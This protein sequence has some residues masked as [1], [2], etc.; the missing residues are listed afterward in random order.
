MTEFS[1]IGKSGNAAGWRNLL[2]VWP[3]ER[4][5]FLSIG[6][7]LALQFSL[8]FTRA[9]N[10]DEFF[11]FSEVQRFAGGELGRGLQTIHVRLFEWLTFLPGTAVDQIVVGRVVMFGFELVTAASIA[12]VARRFASRQVA[13]SCALAYLSAGYVMQHGASFRTDPMATVLLMGAL[14]ILTRSRMNLWAIIAF[15]MLT[16]WSIMVTIKVVLY[17]PAFAGIAWL[18][19]REANGSP[20][21]AARIALAGLL[22]LAVFGITYLLHAAPVQMTGSS[23]PAN[24]VASSS[25]KM[26]SIG[27]PPYWLAA[28]KGAI[29]AIPLT[30]AI[31]LVPGRLF[32]SARPAAER[33]ALAGLFAPLLSLLFYHNTAPYYYAFMLPPVVA[34]CAV[35]LPSMIK[36]YQTA[37]VV[38][39]LTLN[40][41]MV[42]AL[43]GES[44]IGNQRAVLQMADELFPQGTAYFDLCYML[45][46][47]VKVNGFMTPWGVEIYRRAGTPTFANAMAEQPVPLIVENDR[48]FTKLLRETGSAPAF[49][50]ED[51]QA[52]RGSYLPFWGPLWL[53]GQQ[54]SA[55][56]VRRTDIRVPGPY[57]VH[58]GQVTI[59][60]VTYSK[61]ATVT[62]DRGETVLAAGSMPV[63]L[64]WGEKR[65]LPTTA[66][67]QG[68]LWTGF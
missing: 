40:G 59:S 19:W 16:G 6:L 9:I 2:P 27:I 35:S 57:T 18:R 34:A 10:W 41:V 64:W 49:L 12:F 60:G 17:L 54:L 23:D 25:Q 37:G 1:A 31:L 32:D 13:I 47:F 8:V 68:E 66:P 48:M 63:T 11:Y 28:V 55:R 51:I 62:L 7:V 50:P 29:L 67:P 4:W 14:A 21:M 53:A 43:D 46:T 26:F 61:G 42:W 20:A 52:I 65:N 45:P 24:I 36:R 44:R 33:I 5:Q 30:A 56:E 38:F 3:I 15:A 58:G 39:A 22:G